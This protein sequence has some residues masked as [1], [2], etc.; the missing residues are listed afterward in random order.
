M[1]MG[2]DTV[3]TKFLFAAVRFSTKIVEKNSRLLNLRFGSE[4]KFA[5]WALS[6]QYVSAPP[7]TPLLYAQMS[8]CAHC[9]A[10]VVFVRV[11]LN[12]LQVIEQTKETSKR[13]FL[14]SLAA[15]WR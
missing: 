7:Y 5:W 12:R 10:D 6:A 8:A 4:L 15:R 3:F 11:R 1:I 9:S 2:F 14:M 13:P